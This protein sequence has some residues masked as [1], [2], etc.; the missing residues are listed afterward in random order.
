MIV[1]FSIIMLKDFSSLTG[2]VWTSNATSIL[3]KLYETK[4]EMLET[5]KRKKRIWL[6]ISESLKDHNIDV[7]W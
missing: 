3:L 1:T 7:S 4:L 5:P 6:A 2:A